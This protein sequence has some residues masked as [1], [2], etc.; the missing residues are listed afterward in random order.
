MRVKV[1]KEGL[2]LAGAL[3][4][5]LASSACC[6]GP[7]VLAVAGIGGAASALALAPYRR[8]LLVLTAGLLGLAFFLAY[9]RP[10]TTCGPGEECERPWASRPRR[11]LLW[12]VT[13]VVL[14]ATTFPCY[15]RWLF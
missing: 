6:L 3:A 15:S 12:L 14:A 11:M 1:S 2:T 7:M 4:A 13:L 8:F 5:G 10:A 9:R